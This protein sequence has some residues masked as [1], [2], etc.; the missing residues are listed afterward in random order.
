MLSR[1]HVFMRLWGIAVLSVLFPERICSSDAT[2]T[3]RIERLAGL[4]KLWG[5]LKYFHPYLAYKNIDW[6]RALMETIPQV[7]GAES[8]ED[9]AGAIA[10]LVSFLDDPLTRVDWK[11]QDDRE[12]DPEKD[13]DV[14]S[15][16]ES[17]KSDEEQ[18][19]LYKVDVE[20]G[21]PMIVAADYERVGQSGNIFEGLFKDV[22]LEIED[23][24]GVIIDLRSKG[25]NS[26]LQASMG[27]WMLANSL[28]TDLPLLLDRDVVVSSYRSRVH[29]G[30][31][32]QGGLQSGDNWSGF[33]SRDHGMLR[34][35]GGRDKPVSF[36]F[37]LNEASVGF[38][39][40]LAGL[41]N[42][43]LATVIIQGKKAP[44]DSLQATD[45]MAIEGLEV[46]MRREELVNPDGSVGF[47][48]DFSLPA[49]NIGKTDPAVNLAVRV[50]SGSV[51]PAKRN[52]NPYLPPVHT[53]EEPY[54]DE[55]YP[56][57]ERRL[58]GLF[59]LW[60]IIDLFFPYRDLMDRNWEE[61]LLEAIPQFEA[62][63]DATEYALAVAET[64]AQIQDTH[65]SV[66]SQELWNYFG[67][68]HPPIIVDFVEGETVVVYVDESCADS[69]IEIGDV[70]MAV[71][72]EPMQERRTRLGRYLSSS[73][74]QA[75]NRLLDHVVLGGPPGSEMTLE[76]R[77][78]DSSRSIV[79]NREESVGAY[80]QKIQA[81]KKGCPYRILPQNIGYA[82]LARL[83]LDEVPAM[84]DAFAQLPAIIFDIRG[85]P[86]YVVARALGSS[87]AEEPQPAPPCRQPFLISPDSTVNATLSSNAIIE[88]NDKWN[89]KGE[90]VVLI[91]E[92]TIS[93]AEHTCLFIEQTA[94]H[95][96]FIGSPTNGA[97][98]DVTEFPLP[99]GI[100]VCFSGYDIRHA[101]GRQLQRIGIQPD[102]RVEPTIAGI[103]EGRD[104]VLERA[105]D[106]LLDALAN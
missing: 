71:D 105:V 11:D 91:N 21:W 53:I 77:G 58:L 83:E 90:I 28:R 4:C 95:A 60:N 3:K 26:T 88:P 17:G 41:Q 32:T 39:D 55:T 100:R 25:K 34:A 62:A 87:L 99:G 42:A 72:G 101:D 5:R 52:T 89:Y 30:Y 46:R 2:E 43:G 19:L 8:R 49:G 73:T 102:V 75:L 85:Y 76:I 50:L 40:I 47:S 10:Y 23:T 38:Q 56:S 78:V 35:A 1:I 82:D 15:L 66:F 51:S 7:N 37:L 29:A 70:V 22:F 65:G 16:T 45:V 64:A 14:L 80:L 69:G 103:R 84:F 59:R 98:G 18:Q 36:V 57:K 27:A 86:K 79:L 96:V 67:T 13:L 63:E 33:I 97:N 92:E 54:A 44:A 94:R 68:D 12:Q 24:E 61:V 20:G 104:R 31:L 74:P 81:T 48:P 9:Y 93:L 6:D 106:F